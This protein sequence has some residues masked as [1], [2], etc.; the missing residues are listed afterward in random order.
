MPLI[1]SHF[2]SALPQQEYRYGPWRLRLFGQAFGDQHRP[3]QALSAER[4]F[5]RLGLGSKNRPPLTDLLLNIR[6]AL[7]TLDGAFIAVLEHLS[8]PSA[9][10]FQDPLGNW[11]AHWV[12]LDGKLCLAERPAGLLPLLAQKG[13]IRLKSQRLAE[14]FAAV[15][16]AADGGFFEA[17]QVL[18]PGHVLSVTAHGENAALSVSTHPGYRLPEE[19]LWAAFESKAV[20]A[21]ENEENALWIRRLRT[22]LGDALNRYTGQPI[23]LSLSGGLD[24]GLLAGLLT[25]HHK[26]TNGSPHPGTRSAT[27]PPVE[28]ITYQFR[29]FPQADESQWTTHYATGPMALNAFDASGLLPLDDPWPVLP[30]APT[31]TPWRHIKNA[32]YQHSVARG[33][34]HLLTGVYADHLHTGW[35]YHGMD[36]W[37]QS[38]RHAIREAWRSSAGL[39]QKLAPFAS[40]KWRKPVSKRAS[41]LRHEWQ[42]RLNQTLPWPPWHSN[43]PHPQQALLAAG[44]YAADSVWLEDIFAREAGVSLGHPYRHRRVMETLMQAP[45]W[46]LGNRGDPKKLMRQ[47]TAGLVPEAIIKRREGRTLVPVFVAGVLAKHQQ[48]VRD[49]LNRQDASWQA[50]VRPE[51][52]QAVLN[53]A[54]GAQRESDYVALWQCISYELWREALKSRYGTITF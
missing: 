39:K 9:W 19:S 40:G 54:P 20:T 16:P 2:S 43:H 41:W 1:S 30:D 6:R 7:A 51:R 26:G 22:C 15:A 45:A 10:V 37:R 31:S 52:I 42:R 29:D 13:P 5:N 44:L 8:Q 12:C 47:A 3:H 27:I 33:T 24:S 23:A 14:H 50:F 35:I 21:C 4:L 36:R 11:R 17:L 18:L 46:V 48:K 28:A 38:P 25:A 32:L 49:L 34:T 53:S